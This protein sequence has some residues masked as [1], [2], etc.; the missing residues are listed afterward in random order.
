MRCRWSGHDHELYFVDG[1]ELS[2]RRDHGHLEGCGQREAGRVPVAYRGEPQPGDLTQ[3]CRM[4]G[5]ESP[6]PDEAHADA[7]GALGFGRGATDGA[8]ERAP[9]VPVR[10]GARIVAKADVG[11]A[12]SA[13]GPAVR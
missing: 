6:I 7:A 2:S 1:E 13:D 11:E 5:A 8:Q 9:K 4:R 12:P 10:I 3:R